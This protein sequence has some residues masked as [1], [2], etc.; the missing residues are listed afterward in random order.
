[1]ILWETGHIL[2]E[3]IYP[4][5]NFSSGI[6]PFGKRFEQLCRNG[7]TLV[8]PPVDTGWLDYFSFICDGIFFV[9]LALFVFNRRTQLL[10]WNVFLKLST[11]AVQVAVSCS[12]FVATPRECKVAQ[13]F[14]SLS[15]SKFHNATSH[16]SLFSFQ[17]WKEAFKQG[18]CKASPVVEMATLFST[19]LQS[20][21]VPNASSSTPSKPFPNLGSSTSSS[22]SPPLLNPLKCLSSLSSPTPSPAVYTSSSLNP[23]N[24]SM[25]KLS[26]YSFIEGMKRF[27]CSFFQSSW[28]TRTILSC[29]SDQEEECSELVLEESDNGTLVGSKP[30]DSITT[31]DFTEENEKPRWLPKWINLTSEDG[32][33]IVAAFAVSILFRWFVAEPRFIPSLSMYPTFEIGDRIIA[34]KVCYIH[35]V[36]FSYT[37]CYLPAQICPNCRQLWVS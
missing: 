33:T 7:T 36:Q 15:C 34:E 22:L 18:T 6:L 26:K 13:F 27:P 1:M 3:T 31:V 9:S 4:P 14:V 16:G 32:K 2:A 30:V 10:L 12:T 8:S 35:V 28:Q 21:V 29:C 24:T 20:N 19:S 5:S 17:P 37:L 11:M 25:P 23:E